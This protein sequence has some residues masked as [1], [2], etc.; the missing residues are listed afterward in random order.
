MIV[1]TNKQ[2][3]CSDLPYINS[4]SDNKIVIRSNLN[5]NLYVKIT[6]EIMYANIGTITTSNGQTYKIPNGQ[7]S[8]L[9]LSNLIITKGDTVL[10]LNYDSAVVD[11]CDNYYGMGKYGFTWIA[12]L[13]VVSCAGIVLFFIFGGDDFD[14]GILAIVIIVVSI[15]LVLGMIIINSIGNGC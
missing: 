3:L 8:P 6:F 12:L 10:Y 14:A 11:T 4:S 2:Y 13:I 5:N 9:T 15:I 1:E 7:T